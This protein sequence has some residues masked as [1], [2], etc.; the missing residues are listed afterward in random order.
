MY[1][2]DKFLTRTNLVV[3]DKCSKVYNDC[4]SIPWI[5]LVSYKHVNKIYFGVKLLF[6]IV[7][8][9]SKMRQ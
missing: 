3:I 8:I 6:L 5:T 7:Q 1:E 2:Q 4:S 9:Q